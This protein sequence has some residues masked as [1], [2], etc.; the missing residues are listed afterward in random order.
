MLWPHTKT[1]IFTL[2]VNLLPTTGCARLEQF[3]NDTIN[4]DFTFLYH[5]TYLPRIML[6]KLTIP[7][8]FKTFQLLKGKNQ[9]LWSIRLQWS[10]LTILAL[11][12]R[13]A[14]LG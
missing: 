14:S 12:K 5:N 11:S 13:T 3:S 2:I 10:D 1:F 4:K 6:I 8:S 9:N 7:P